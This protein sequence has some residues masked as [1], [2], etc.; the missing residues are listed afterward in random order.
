MSAGLGEAHQEPINRRRALRI[1]VGAVTVSTS[2]ILLSTAPANALQHLWSSCTRCRGVWFTGNGT[3]GSCPAG[4]IF[5]GGHHSSG[6][7]LVLKTREDGGAGQSGWNWCGACQGLW[8]AGN[9]SFGVCPGNAYG[10][11]PLSQVGLQPGV[12]SSDYVIEDIDHRDR[13]GGLSGWRW[14]SKCSGLWD[15]NSPG[16]VCPRDHAPHTLAGSGNYVLRR[17]GATR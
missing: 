14:C 10:H 4:N 3:R 1:A 17:F 2:A 5:D 9:N 11:R 13:S 7:D 6:L 16:S 8:F 15:N 12:F